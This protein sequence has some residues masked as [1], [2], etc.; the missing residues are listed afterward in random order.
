MGIPL[1]V[2]SKISKTIPLISPLDIPVGVQPEITL[3]FY[4]EL[5]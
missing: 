5:L 1:G 3:A 4:R 2:P